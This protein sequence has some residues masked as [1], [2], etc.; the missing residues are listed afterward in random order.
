MLLDKLVAVSPRGVWNLNQSIVSDFI[1]EWACNEFWRSCTHLP[2][3]LSC[4]IFKMNCKDFNLLSLFICP[5]LEGYL[6]CFV[7]KRHFSTS[8]LLFLGL[9]CFYE[10]K[11]YLFS[12]NTYLQLPNS[13]AC[14]SLLSNAYL[15]NWKKQQIWRKSGLQYLKTHV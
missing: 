12:Q 10:I 3:K 13:A 14:P 4:Q 5:Y 9:V 8:Y 2:T 1:S 6:L 11:M 7:K 15:K